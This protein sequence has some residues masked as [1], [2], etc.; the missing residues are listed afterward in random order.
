VLHVINSLGM[1]GGAEQQ[2][3]NNLNRF[4]D[5]RMR[6]VVATVFDY[7]AESVV[8]QVSPVVEV[9]KLGDTDAKPSLAL[10]VYRLLRLVREVRPDLIHATLSEA[11]WVSRAV[12][13]LSRTAVTESLVNISHEPIRT[14][15]S[16]GVTRLKLGIHAVGD[17]LTARR[18]R[19]FHAL[20]GRVA[21][22]WSRVVG[23]PEDKMVVIPRGVDP[24]EFSGAPLPR[25]DHLEIRT[26]VDVPQ[27]GFVVTNVGR[28]EPQKGQRYL[29][30]AVAELRRRGLDDIYVLLIGRPASLTGTLQGMIDDLG[31]RDRVRLLGRRQDVRQCLAVSDCFVFPSLYEGMGVSLL[32]AMVT[33]L[34]VAASD[35]EPLR[36]I[37]RPEH[38]G[39]VFP[40][41]SP[42]AIA[43]SIARLRADAALRA[44]LGAAA[45]QRVVDN[46]HVERTARSFEAFLAEHVGLDASC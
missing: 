29:I 40:P 13:A 18:T 14:L 4:A 22:S 17:R 38:A 12:G 30:E 43:E 37:V 36:S 45:R 5:H 35:V 20:S 15:D 10:V 28:H 1:S 42:S 16:Q 6:Y 31:L 41:A 7:A 9:V 24:E 2:L 3:L 11:A 26:R 27:D 34:P 32:E 23:I 46:Y 39:V 25:T 8:S 21:A 19:A 44:R 33:G